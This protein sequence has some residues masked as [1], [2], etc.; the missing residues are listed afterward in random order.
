MNPPRFALLLLAAA[1]LSA[2]SEPVKLPDPIP[3]DTPITLLPIPE[4]GPGD[5]VT[6]KIPG[7]WTTVTVPPGP[8][9]R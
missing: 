2:C 1:I 9:V 7:G 4:A 8:P 5:T 3:T 6:I